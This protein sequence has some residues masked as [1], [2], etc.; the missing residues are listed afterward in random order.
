MEILGKTADGAV[1]KNRPKSHLHHEMEKLIPE[2]LAMVEVKGNGFVVAEVDFRK[3]IG[4]SGC[5]STG[6]TDCII[7]AQRP[8]RKGLTRFVLDKEKEPTSKAVI[9]LK[10]TSP[11]E[12]VLITAFIGSKAEVEPWDVNATPKSLEYWQ[13]NALVWGEPICKGTAT[14]ERQW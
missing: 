2:A 13:N 8:D 10:Q 5:V 4:L 9:V 14:V 1:V 12:Y 7:F 3:T 6:P 11:K